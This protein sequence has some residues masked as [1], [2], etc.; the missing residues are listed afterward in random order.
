MAT[1]TATVS[2]NTGGGG[3]GGSGGNA[4][5]ALLAAAAASMH[6]QKQT[7]SSNATVFMNNIATATSDRSRTHTKSKNEKN[8]IGI[9][10]NNQD[11]S[12]NNN[13]ID[14]LIKRAQQQQ[15]RQQQHQA[16]TTTNI[17]NKTPSSSSG[18][19]STDS[20]SNAAKLLVSLING[21][22]SPK[23]SSSVKDDQCV[24][25]LRNLE[26]WH[27]EDAKK[28]DESHYQELV[29]LGNSNGW[30]ADEMFKYN[31]KMHKI[32]SSYSE[33]V[34]SGNYTTPLP[35]TNS[36]TTIRL[37]GQLAKEIEDRVIAEGRITPESSDDDELFENER[38][39]RKQIN[40]Q[41]RLATQQRSRQ[42]PSNNHSFMLHTNKNI[43]SSSHYSNST[44][45][46]ATASLSSSPTMND[47]II[48]PVTCSSRNILRTCL[49]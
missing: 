27:D 6:Q 15:H 22:T 38:L 47:T 39:R 12:S 45:T 18:S 21:K 31:E 37:A 46:P 24:A 11:S 1:S 26:S 16:T 19:T 4:L 30:S 8:C 35:K 44:E 28:L 10:N 33:K 25:E 14:A 48:K 3:G 20:S 43:E 7:S 23:S 2:T 49:T 36:K 9:I 13:L 29:E 41:R 34:L 32:T 40:Q 17:T 5:A 42:R